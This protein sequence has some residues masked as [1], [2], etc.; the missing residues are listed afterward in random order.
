MKRPEVRT[1]LD[2]GIADLAALQAGTHELCEAGHMYGEDE[3]LGL[4]FQQVQATPAIHYLLMH[5]VTPN[6]VASKGAYQPRA[7]LLRS[8]YSRL[9][10][11]VSDFAQKKI[12]NFRHTHFAVKAGGTTEIMEH[13]QHVD[14]TFSAHPWAIS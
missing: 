14:T 11:R 2:K 3:A 8:L 13:A 10:S 6:L 1:A 5:H 7:D 12:E 4:I 9:V